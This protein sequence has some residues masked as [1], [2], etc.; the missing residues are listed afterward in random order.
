MPL[1]LLAG[2]G[3]KRAEQF[4]RLGLETVGD[5]L[6]FYP[7][8]YENFGEVKPINQVQPGKVAI[9]ARPVT[10]TGRYVRRG[11]HIT[12]AVV[13][14]ASGELRVVWFNQPYRAAQINTQKEYYFSGEYEFGRGRYVLN[15]PQAELAEHLE[16]NGSNITPVY[17]E[18]KGLTSVIIRKALDSILPLV[19]ELP[20]TL[21]PE[22]LQQ[23]K[24]MPR[25]AAL[26]A[27]HAPQTTQDYEAARHRF[28]FEELLAVVL[29]AAMNKQENAALEAWHIPFDVAAAKKFTA[30]LPF[31]L[32][33]A[34]RT[35]VWDIIQNLE[36]GTPMNRLLQGDVGSG[37]TVVAAM[38]AYMAAQAGYQTAFMAPTELLAAQ[39][40]TT[41]DRLL[42]PHHITVALLTGS[43]KTKARPALLEGIESGAIAV[44]VGTHALI[45]PNVKFHSLGFV[46]IDEQHR[47][48]VEQRRTLV[49]KSRRMPHLLSM[50]ATPI[51][52]SLALTVYGELD[53]SILNELPPGRTP[54][55]T[56]IGSPNSRE[57]IY[58]LADTAIAEGRQ[59]YVICPQIEPTEGKAKTAKAK[60]DDDTSSVTKAFQ[61]ISG[62][63]L[64][65]RRVAMLHGKM[66]AEEKAEVMA[67]FAAGDIDVL[68]STTVIE[69]GVDVPNATVM[70]IENADHFGLAQLHQLRGRVGR[71]QHQSY[72]YLIPATS[73]APSRRL[74]ELEQS[75]DGFYLSE[76]DLELRG[77]GEV[78]GAAQHG[79]LDMRLA[80]IGDLRFVEMVQKAALWLLQEGIDISRYPELHDRVERA[81]RMITLN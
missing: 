44:T 61:K 27:I 41:L 3:P 19:D 75:T 7:R 73:K 63:L 11:L 40:A 32:T 5:L 36:A 17:R 15:N 62:N 8:T 48:G 70:I 21:P 29:A 53:V 34:Q 13:A 71:G 81:R 12:E 6:H 23:Y 28:G 25:P 52:R 18:T 51:P 38:A 45:Q 56:K 67:G 1:S 20:E 80:R 76:V 31:Q 39:H 78:Y 74:R 22:L 64:K 37:K 54:I 33:N 58:G 66:K 43:V 14:D 2:I 77:P 16:G 55:V 69:V 79:Q 59:V 72:C 57:K 65:H 26:Q 42:A 68:V 35:A 4:A 49:D 47:F 10:V 9:V 50:S 24:L 46:V 60:S 30:A